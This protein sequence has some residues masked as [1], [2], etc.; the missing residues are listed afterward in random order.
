M[1]RR[2][3]G[4]IETG[5]ANTATVVGVL[6]RLGIEARSLEHSQDAAGV[7]SLIIPGV[8]AF[9]PALVN[10]ERTGWHDTLSSHIE[11]GRPLLGI[12]LGMQI[13][14]RSSEESPGIRGLGLIDAEVV[15]LAGGRPR[16]GWDTLSPVTSANG[17]SQFHKAIGDQA[18]YFNHNFRLQ[19]DP[20][21]LNVATFAASADSDVPAI[22]EFGNIVGVQFH[23]E[24]SQSVGRQFLRTWA[25]DWE[26]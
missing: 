12:C 9:G 18:V 15:R 23:P 5:V 16:I 8:G 26:A 1:S 11:R 2:R 4:V 6:R 14:A 21:M 13:L 25:L 7:D 24:R 3:V 20:A 17:T 10:M 19:F 22:I